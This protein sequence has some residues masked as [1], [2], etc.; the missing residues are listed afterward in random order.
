MSAAGAGGRRAALVAA[1][2]RWTAKWDALSQRERVLIL[3][4]AT[5]LVTLPGYTLLLGPAL[6]RQRQLA[7]QI[8][9]QKSQAA[10]LETQLRALAER[11]RADPDAAARKQLELSRQQLARVDHALAD[12]EKGLVSPESMATLL[13]DMLRR[14]GMPRLIAL[15]TLPAAA[16]ATDDQ[17][18]PGAKAPASS[19]EK[20]HGVYRHGVELTVEGGYPDLLRYL[21]QLEALPWRMFWSKIEIKADYPKATM[22]LTLYTLSLDPTWLSI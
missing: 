15:K 22:T 1:W 7:D 3:A 8:A 11:L 18:K 5:V 2:R 16:L 21:T 4:A 17:A 9:Q 14:D 12:L 10:T 19:A 20:G 6:A 13:E